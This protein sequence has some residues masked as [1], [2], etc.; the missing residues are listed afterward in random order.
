MI[1]AAGLNSVYVFRIADRSPPLPSMAGG[2]NYSRIIQ[3]VTLLVFALGC[4]VRYTA[5]WESLDA[6]PL[7]QWFDDS[8]FGIFIHWGVFSVPGFGKFSEW[9]WYWWKALKYQQE[10]EFMRKNYPPDF[11]YADFAKEFHAEFFDPNGW[12][13]ILEVSGAKYVVF[14]SKHHDGFTNW[15]SPTSWNWNSVDVG[16]HRDL[17]GELAAAVR[18][19]NLHFGLYHSMF[20]WFNPLYLADAASGFKNQDFVFGKAL[21]ELVQLV[22]NYKP[23]LIW[24]DGDW[25]APDTYWNSTEFLAWLYNDSPVKDVVV[26]NDRWGKGCYCKHGGYY[27]CADRYSP[28]E[29]PTHKW[30]KCQTIDSLSWGYRRYMKATELLTLPNILKDMMYVVAFGGN[31]LL[32]IGPM[33]DGMIPPVFEERLRDI[34][35]W[36]KINGEAV[37]GSKAWRNQTE[38][39]VAPLYYTAKNNSVYAVIFGWPPNQ[40]LQ[41][42]LPKTSKATNVTLLDYPNMPL[43]WKPVKGGGLVISMP[44]MAASA[45]NAWTLKLEGAA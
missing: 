28:T 11:Q 35:S 37:Y 43:T 16:P 12:A 14:T 9:F 41:L 4:G 24:S 21:P 20:E 3:I 25:T 40:R 1:I 22:K 39:A 8:K 30:E 27:N 5:D 6:R 45:G 33:S 13:E 36:L 34:G 32:N 17:V 7:P 2:I 18:K 10:I 19:K 26:T 42:S 29:V 44:P 15:P 31:Y 38:P 23:D